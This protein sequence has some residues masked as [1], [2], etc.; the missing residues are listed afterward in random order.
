MP[1]NQPL[2]F[3]CTSTG[4]V[5]PTICPFVLAARMGRGEGEEVANT[6]LV[7]PVIEPLT[8]EKV[9]GWE[10]CLSIPGLRGLV[11]PGGKPR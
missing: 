6:V 3:G 4:P 7:N 8:D 5:K 11:P 2:P 1:V 10:G 9:L